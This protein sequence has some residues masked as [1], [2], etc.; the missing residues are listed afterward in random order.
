MTAVYLL[1]LRVSLS[2]V[3][4]GAISVAS[5]RANTGVGGKSQWYCV[6]QNVV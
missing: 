2:I 1:L 6:Y 4:P 3:Q 5:Q